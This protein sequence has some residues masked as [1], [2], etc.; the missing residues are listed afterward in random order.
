MANGNGRWWL[1]TALA[2][3]TLLLGW[4]MGWGLNVA[5]VSQAAEDIKQ[6]QADQKAD[7][8]CIVEVRTRLVSIDASLCEIKVILKEHTSAQP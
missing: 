3:G 1:T 8:D 4:G 5:A 6:L 2:V 7:H